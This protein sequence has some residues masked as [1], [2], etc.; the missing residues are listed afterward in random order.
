M[1]YADGFAAVDIV[2]RVFSSQVRGEER[3]IK[4]AARK[5]F[6]TAFAAWYKEII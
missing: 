4:V 2:L 6:Q 3:K 5:D 1:G